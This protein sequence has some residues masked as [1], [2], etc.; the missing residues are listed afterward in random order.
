MR[1]TSICSSS[2]ILHS[3]ISTNLFHCNIECQVFDDR[4]GEKKPLNAIN[5]AK[6]NFRRNMLLASSGCSLQTVAGHPP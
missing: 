3:M 6:V 5:T 2:M 4:R 1:M